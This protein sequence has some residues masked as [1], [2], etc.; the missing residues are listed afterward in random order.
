MIKS[1][2][3]GM[4][5]P[6]L[7]IFGGWLRFLLSVVSINLANGIPFVYMLIGISFGCG[8][9]YEDITSYWITYISGMLFAFLIAA[10]VGK[11]EKKKGLSGSTVSLCSAGFVVGGLVG[12]ILDLF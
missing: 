9:Y 11:Y 7:I 4:L 12:M 8:T 10:W 2:F 1:V 3:V 6:L 5:F